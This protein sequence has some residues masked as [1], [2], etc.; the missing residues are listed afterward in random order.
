MKRP[1]IIINE[2]KCNGCG[3]CI[4]NCPEGALQIING[5][6]RLISDLF[7]DGLGACIGH[8][9]QEAIKTEVREAEAY[10]EKK[11][12]ENIIKGGNEV[13][14]AHLKH[15][16]SHGETNFYNQAIEV[17]KEKN[18][19]LP[20]IEENDGHG[21]SCPGSQ[22]RDFREDKKLAQSHTTSNAKIE[23]ELRQWP[24]QLHLVNPNAPYFKNT[25]LVVA[26]D[27]VPFAYADF[28]RK[29]IKDKAIVIF[30]P[31]LDDSH[32]KYVEK[33]ALIILNNEI[34]T[35]WTI[36][37][38]VPCCFGTLKIVEDAIKKAGTNTII[39]EYTISIQGSL[40]I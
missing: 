40:T 8:C 27:C 20:V 1:I 36:H 19:P 29:F 31:K 16:K 25:D 24:V 33:L 37:M 28:H 15:L 13:I 34:K 18:I 7:C 35:I 4:P 26:A 6:V 3:Q 17:L 38:E 23:S 39:K 32:E 30:C 9:P 5:K 10:S 14:A 21:F 2:E 11:V 12:M 22:M